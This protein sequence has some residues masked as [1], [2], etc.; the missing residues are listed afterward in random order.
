MSPFQGFLYFAKRNL[1]IVLPSLRDYK[2][3][4]SLSL[5]GHRAVVFFNIGADEK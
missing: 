3:F 5:K 2:A 1:Y 4:G